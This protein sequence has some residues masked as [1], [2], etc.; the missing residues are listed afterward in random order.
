MYT[1]ITMLSGKM[2]N[3][4]RELIYFFLLAIVILWSF[5][6]ILYIGISSFKLPTD[7]W[8]YPPKFTGPFTFVNYRILIQKWPKYF[9][10][11]RNSLIIT[12]GTGLITLFCSITAAFAFSRFRAKF[13]KLSAFFLIAMRMVPPIVITIPLFPLLNSLGLIDKHITLIILYSAFL[14]SLA[15]WIM[16]TFIDDVPIELEE[17]AMIDGCS[18]VQALLKITFPLAAPGFVAVIIFTSILA[19]NEYLFAFVFS[20]TNARTAPVALA[21]FMGAIMGVDWGA[22]L[23]ASI[24]HLVPLLSLIWIIQKHLIRGMTVGAIK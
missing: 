8:D 16:K 13:L 1:T 11:L 22:L 14:V 10:H 19:W 9:T 21:E 20:S 17:A 18:K 3:I 2:K 5:F 23:A 24:I 15:T 4:R 12:L 6:P 7:I